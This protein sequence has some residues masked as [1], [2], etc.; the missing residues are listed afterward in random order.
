MMASSRRDLWPR[1]CPQRARLWLRFRSCFSAAEGGAGAGA[2]GHRAGG[3]SAVP[4]LPDS[5]SSLIPA[6]LRKT[7]IEVTT[8]KKKPTRPSEERRPPTTTNLIMDLQL[9]A[10]KGIP[11]SKS[12]ATYEQWREHERQM[13]RSQSEAELALAKQNKED[14]MLLM[15]NLEEHHSRVR[16]RQHS[17]ASSTSGDSGMGY[18]TKPGLRNGP[19]TPNKGKGPPLSRSGSRRSSAQNSSAAPLL[20][21]CLSTP[22]PTREREREKNSFFRYTHDGC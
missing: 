12:L 7:T 10:P 20:V 21:S 5:S 11:K 13:K 17:N 18:I 1:T 15:N 19:Y 14:Q 6:S 3:P 2:E 4:D 8:K 22:P 9:R 16:L